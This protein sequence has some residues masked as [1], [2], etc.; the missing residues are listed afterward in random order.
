MVSEDGKVVFA[1]L[2]EGQYFGEVSLIFNRPRIVSIRA[3]TNC[4]LFALGQDDLHRTL[5]SYPHIEKQVRKVAEK[6]A[7]LAKV[8]SLIASQ[9]LAEGRSPSY[10]AKRG[11]RLTQDEDSEGAVLYRAQSKAS[12]RERRRKKR[13]GKKV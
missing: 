8:R 4:D 11:A 9:A 6:R 7:E 10:A 13:Q 5:A 12:R 2:S 3:A 1:Q